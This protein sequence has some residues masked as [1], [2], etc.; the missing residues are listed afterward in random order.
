M[1]DHKTHSISNSLTTSLV[2]IIVL[3]S[4][5]FI[6]FY[7]YQISRRANSRLEKTANEYIQSIS[8]TLEIP[9][10]DMDRENINTVCN[11][12][13]RNDWII[14]VKLTGVSGE[15]MYH[16]KIKTDR[17]KET[18]INR[19]REISHNGEII[20]T[21]TIDLSSFESHKNKAELLK[22]TIAALLI[23]IVGL[24]FFTGFL[25][26][27]FIQEPINFLGR[28]AQSY[29]KGDYHPKPSTT[30]YKEFEPFIMLL[31][32]MG[33]TIESQMNELKYAEESLKKHRDSL[34]EKVAQRTQ[35]LKL[36]NKKLQNEIQHRK[37]AQEKLHINE[38]R[39]E[40]ILRSSPI[41]IG[42]ESNRQ[43]DW[44]N[45]T[46]HRMLKYEKGA[47]VGENTGILYKNHAEYERVNKELSNRFSKS[48]PES[49]ET[50]WVRKDGT[51]FDCAIRVY[52]LDIMEW[53]KGQIFAVTD[54]TDR[55]KSEQALREKDRLQG[56]LELSGAI[57]HEMTQPLMSAMGYFDL[58][59]LD[60]SE[61][62]SNRYKIDK[63][64][65]Q[66]NRMSDI[67]KKLMKISR[68]QTKDYLNKKILDL[69]KTSQ[70][71]P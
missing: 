37:H 63:I 40:A 29:S 18:V 24:I 65:F 30:T 42:L 6:S 52:P 7:Y 54:I 33:K 70:R 47:L 34:E 25:L 59:V 39:L 56:V 9:L 10:W 17:I 68:Y 61:N 41:G 46:M 5:A 43:L 64:K 12:Y 53:S 66:L 48:S 22:A 11:Y 14:M 38:Q 27:K 36:S 45:E 55:K 16:E 35:E 44:V 23:S 62:D 1:I 67:T 4:T 2:I 3:L 21:V 19:S 71:D 58:M 57:C 60:M 49:V 51:F 32:D 31:F 13:I 15:V 50:Q 26:K 69:S 28:I 20:G 8:S